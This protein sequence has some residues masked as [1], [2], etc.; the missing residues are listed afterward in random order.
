MTKQFNKV[1]L[2]DG[3]KEK[4]LSERQ[5]G[6]NI[7]GW[8]SEILWLIELL[9]VACSEGAACQGVLLL[10]LTG[11]SPLC[12]V[13]SLDRCARIKLTSHTFPEGRDVFSPWPINEAVRS[14]INVCGLGG[15]FMV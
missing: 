15:I 8:L 1:F 10:P 9:A 12:N 13:H 6:P 2:W 5:M 3:L 7:D 4:D 11:P 14:K